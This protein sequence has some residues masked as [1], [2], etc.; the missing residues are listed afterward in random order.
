MH[1]KAC[2]Q[3]ER[4]RNRDLGT[5]LFSRGPFLF[6]LSFTVGGDVYLGSTGDG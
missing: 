1:E 3:V 5:A 2:P 4:Y 6:F